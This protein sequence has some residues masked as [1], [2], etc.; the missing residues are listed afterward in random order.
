MDNQ[1]PPPPPPPP[2]TYV[3]V[4]QA[5]PHAGRVVAQQ[6]GLRLTPKQKILVGAGLIVLLFFGIIGSCHQQMP[7]TPRQVAMTNGSSTAPASADMIERDRRRAE[8]E[9]ERNGAGQK[10]GSSPGP[11][12]PGQS[13]GSPASPLADRQQDPIVQ[14]RQ[15]LRAEDMKRE[16][17]AAYVS[18]V[19]FAIQMPK[20][21]EDS[22]QL[23]PSRAEPGSME[24]E[25]ASPTPRPQAAKEEKK[26]CDVNHPDDGTHCLNEGTIL[27]NTLL[28]RLDGEYAGP[29]ICQI[30]IDVYDR[31]GIHLLI[32][33]GS[34]VIG[35]AKPVSSQNQRRLAVFF[36]RILM[37]DG[38]SLSLD[39]FPGL[40]QIG[41]T[42]L[43]SKVN[44]HYLQIFASS[45][46]IGAVA[47]LAQMGNYG[48]SY[49]PLTGFR[50]GFTEEGAESAMQV[51]DRFLNRQPTIIVNPGTRVKII[52][53]ADL[54]NVPEYAKHTVNPNL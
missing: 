13:P 28:N 50:N 8:Q 34:K 32:P 22:A 36:H 35:E 44:N 52:L 14:L 33:A 42:G 39:K 30:S 37:P 19:T 18:G 9:A 53:T 48:V 10:P 4:Q 25:H 3:Y 23:E 1:Q 29:V 5:D 20:R 24:P 38:Y 46:A 6:E 40:D 17:S 51:L 11:V 31:S 45:L 41:D 27:E 21:E 26:T 7:L 47:G 43:V 16:A 54:P 12:M 15:Q 49:T 2:P